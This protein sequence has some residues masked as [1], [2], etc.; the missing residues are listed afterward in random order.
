MLESKPEADTEPQ[1]GARAGSGYTA[2][3][4]VEQ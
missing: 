2:R 3:A 1:M 4:M